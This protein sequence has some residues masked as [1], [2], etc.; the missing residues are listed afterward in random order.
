LFS[1]VLL[2]ALLSGCGGQ[3]DAVPPAPPQPLI[4]SADPKPGEAALPPMDV[5][6][7]QWLQ[8]AT[9]EDENVDPQKLSVLAGLVGQYEEGYDLFFELIGNP[10]TE[11]HL[12]MMATISMAQFVFPEDTSRLVE[13]TQPELDETTRGCAAH[14]LC[15]IPEP[16]E[17]GKKR[18]R[19]LMQ[20]DSLHVR[21]AT[22]LAL[23]TKGD[24]DAINAL[25]PLW[26]EEGLNVNQRTSILLTLPDAGPEAF[27]SIY[28]EAVQMQDLSPQ[29]R[30][31]LIEQLSLM[32]DEATLAVLEKVGADDPDEEVR[33]MAQGAAEAMKALMETPLIV[34]SNP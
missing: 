19:E 27:R 33:L 30:L 13:M 5:L 2:A 4:A 17:A 14:L 8:A 7:D 24:I 21:V 22:I 18:L 9:S 29:L 15:S 3:E 32:S 34:N 26:K 16:E 20:D 28:L 10:E 12:K 11:P 1:F 25:S 23:A 6:Y 31:S